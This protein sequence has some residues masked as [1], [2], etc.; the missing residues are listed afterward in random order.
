[1]TKKIHKL[2]EG[3][4]KILKSDVLYH[5]HYCAI[6]DQVA[7]SKIFSNV[8]KLALLSGRENAKIEAIEC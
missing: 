7:V 3:K 5:C 6:S 2:T 1:M 8:S 4:T